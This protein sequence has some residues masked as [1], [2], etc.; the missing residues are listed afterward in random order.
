M[1]ELKK[2]PYEFKT[3]AVILSGLVSNKT[4]SQTHGVLIPSREGCAWLPAPGLLMRLCFDL[5][6]SGRSG[7]SLPY[8]YYRLGSK[9]DDEKNDLKEKVENLE[10]T[11]GELTNKGESKRL[12]RLEKVVHALTRKVLS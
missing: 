11:V 9:K 12:E 7:I 1:P 2:L 5:P 3:A 4:G 6:V 10:K 8:A